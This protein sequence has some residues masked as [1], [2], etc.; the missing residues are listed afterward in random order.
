MLEVRSFSVNIILLDEI[1]KEEIIFGDFRNERL[2]MDDTFEFEAFDI[3]FSSEIK[4]K[5]QFEYYFSQKSCYFLGI[6]IT[7]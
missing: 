1:S 6:L 2:K 4:I 3:I 7:I 5:K